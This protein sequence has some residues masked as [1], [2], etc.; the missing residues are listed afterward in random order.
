MCLVDQTR[1]R[2]T[3]D[4]M[5]GFGFLAYVLKRGFVIRL[6]LDWVLGFSRTYSECCCCCCFVPLNELGQ[7]AVAGTREGPATLLRICAEAAVMAPC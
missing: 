7:S 3:L 6:I 4:V 2:Q 1:V 5:L